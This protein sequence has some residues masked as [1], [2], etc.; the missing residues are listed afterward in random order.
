MGESWE[1]CS[2]RE[3]L[4]ETNLL[5]KDVKY[6]GTTNDI[7]ISGN[8]NKHYITIFMCA[9]I[10]EDS[11][12][13]ENKEPEKCEGWEWISMQDLHRMSIETPHLLFDPLLHYL[14]N[15]G[16]HLPVN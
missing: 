4:E 3:L 15:Y 14:Q 5:I 1:N 8:P 7:A 6:A 16:P 10:H 11:G 2:V 9:S 13:L 12:A